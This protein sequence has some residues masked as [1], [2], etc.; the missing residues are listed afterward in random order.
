MI[1]RISYDFMMNSNDFVVFAVFA[2][3]CY[4]RTLP[5][6]SLGLSSHGSLGS[7]FTVAFQC[8]WIGQNAS[9]PERRNTETAGRTDRQT[10]RLLLRGVSVCVSVC[11][12]ALSL[13]SCLCLCLYLCLSLSLSLSLSFSLYIYIYIHTHMYIY[14]ERERERDL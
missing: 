2:R 12:S 9:V 5:F 7:S 1:S 4:W 10:D 6:Q 11:L 14:R 13:L 3:F 8:A